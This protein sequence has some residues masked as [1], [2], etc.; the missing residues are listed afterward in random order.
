MEKTLLE[1]FKKYE[2]IKNEEK[3]NDLNL[4]SPTTI[5]PLI[6]SQNLKINNSNSIKEINP[7][8]GYFEFEKDIISEMNIPKYNMNTLNFIFHELTSNI[9]DHSK[10]TKGLVMGKNYEEFKEIAFIDNGITIPTSLKNSNFS[11]ENDC[12]AITEA[13]N[14]LST[15]NELGFIERGTGLNNT[16]NIVITVV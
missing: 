5:L 4:L 1:E 3:I 16:I 14:G 11:F 8:K 13:I 12:E 10:F 2:T 6:C 9:Y 15:K 7:K